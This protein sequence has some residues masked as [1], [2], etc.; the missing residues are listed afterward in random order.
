[1]SA[2]LSVLS[3]R[4]VWVALLGILIL[5]GLPKLYIMFERMVKRSGRM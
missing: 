5:W 4:W 3:M 1:M 2:L